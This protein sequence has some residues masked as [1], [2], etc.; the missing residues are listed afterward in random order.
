MFDGTNVMLEAMSKMLKKNGNIFRNNLRRGDLYSNG[1]RGI[2]CRRFPI[3]QW[4]HGDK[5]LKAIRQV[6]VVIDEE[7]L[8]LNLTLFSLTG[9]D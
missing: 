1:S 2:D 5:I 9:Q 7:I 8:T 3:V 6:H 4:E